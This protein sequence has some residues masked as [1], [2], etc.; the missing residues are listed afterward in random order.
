MEKYIKA[1]REYMRKDYK[2]HL[3]PSRRL[4]GFN[5]PQLLNG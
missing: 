2:V 4:V 1:L 5:L 3:L